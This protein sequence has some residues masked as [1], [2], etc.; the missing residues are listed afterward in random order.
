MALRLDP[1]TRPNGLDPRT[2][3]NV[4]KKFSNQ[5]L[6]YRMELE[7]FSN[8]GA[9]TQRS[10]RPLI[11]CINAI[12]LRISSA[13]FTPNFQATLELFLAHAICSIIMYI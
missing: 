13:H 5:S 12:K 6:V 9:S 10:C 7:I 11:C 1:R 2:R 4:W 8:L 3:P